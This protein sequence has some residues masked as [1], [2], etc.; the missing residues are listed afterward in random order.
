MNARVSDRENVHGEQVGITRS[1]LAAVVVNAGG[2]GIRLVVQIVLARALGT[3]DYG[4]FVLGRS[5][6]ELLSRF[7]N[8]GYE[9]AA[10]KELPRYQRSDEAA[11]HLGFVRAAWTTTSVLGL[12]LTGV[13]GLTYVTIVGEVDRAIVVGIFLTAPLA[14]TML[15]RSVLQGRYRFVSGSMLVE[16][17]QPVAFG[18]VI[19]WLWLADHLT[20]VSAVAAWVATMVLA[21]AMGAVLIRRSR[22]AGFEDIEPVRDERSW[23]PTRAAMFASRLAFIVLDSADVLIVGAL[24]SR[25]DVAAYAI[26]TRVA[27]LGRIIVSGVQSVA[28]AHLAEA[29]AASD[30]SASQRIVDRSLRV[31]ALPSVA[32]TA[33]TALFA[34]LVV[35]VFGEGYGAAVTLLRILLIGNLINSVTGPSGYV[36]SLS[37][38][39]GIYA[40]VMWTAAGATIVFVP[41]GCVI[42][43]AAGAAWAVTFVIT[44]W[45]VALL[46][47][48]RRRLGIR[49]W[50]RPATFTRRVTT[51]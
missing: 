9:A 26:A 37:G 20:A 43:G 33:L 10:V 25:A 15:G 7:P 42:C 49:C 32:L 16:V 50:I 47:I 29:A 44:G 12:L 6:G 48:A 5:W 39:E 28:A 40:V 4:R 3:G 45:N 23:R 13:A 36:V 19:G 18:F 8:A 21:A 38:L 46:V 34:G 51:P 14:L 11:L 22:P 31:C 27:V 17:V 2:S 30:W 24:L 35:D 1:S 41:L